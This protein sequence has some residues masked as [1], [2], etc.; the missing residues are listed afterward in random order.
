LISGGTVVVLTRFDAKV[1]ARAIELYRCT[2]WVTATTSLI[3]FLEMPEIEEYDFSSMR[4]LWSGGTPI[5]VEIQKKIGNL[6]PKAIIGEGYG[7]TE[8]VA[9]GGTI[10]PLLRY[11]PGFVGIPQL[12]QIKIMDL[13]TGREELRA[14]EEG[15]IIIKG[16]AVMK[17]YWNRQEETDNTL[18]DGWLYTGDIGAMDDEGYLKIVGRKKELIKCSGFSVFPSEV[19]NLLFKHPGVAEVAVI[20]VA[21]PY[22]GESPKAFII[23]KSEYREKTTEKEIIEWCKENMSTY[24]RPRAV[25]FLEDLPK[26]A[27]GKILRRILS[28][29]EDNQKG[30]E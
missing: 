29:K 26:S 20:G 6:A 17:G 3:A 24:K 21:D 1:T 11:K 13:E 12:N 10:T 15:E 5:S 2:Y 25:E 19:E 27:A 30:G 9:Q 7:L 18:K 28:E 4:C 8:C 16:P 22:R 23:L 14:G